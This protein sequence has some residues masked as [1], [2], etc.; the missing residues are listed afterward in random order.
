M[1]RQ[2]EQSERSRT[3]LFLREHPNHLAKFTGRGVPEPPR[4]KQPF[5]FP[6]VPGS[7]RVLV[8]CSAKVPDRGAARVEVEFWFRTEV[9]GLPRFRL[10]GWSF[11]SR[12]FNTSARLSPEVRQQV[13]ASLN[14]FRVPPIVFTSFLSSRP[15]EPVFLTAFP[16]SHVPRDL[17]SGLRRP[18]APRHAVNKSQT[19]GLCPLPAHLHPRPPPS[20][21]APQGRN[22]F[23]RHDRMT[24]KQLGPVFLQLF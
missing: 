6:P 5:S 24:Q 14:E 17:H 11:L 2:R 13:C 12:H 21:P 10:V 4:R 1:R 19:P 15:Q 3:S 18:R 20:L 7:G 22:T 16:G 23:P 9:K 8:S